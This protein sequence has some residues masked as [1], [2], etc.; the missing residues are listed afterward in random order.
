[1]SL[2]DKYAAMTIPRVVIFFILV[3]WGALTAP[4]QEPPRIVVEAPP[5]LAGTAAQLR[6]VDPARLASVMRLVGLREPGPP[7]RVILAPEES[8]AAGIVPSWVSGYAVG[9][10]GV[11]VL[12][13]GRVPSYPDSS[14][15][16]LLSHEMAHVL[17][18]RAAGGRPLPRWFHEGMA[19]IAGLSWGLDDRS[20]LTLALLVDRPVSLAG[21]DG[22]FAGGQSEVN[23]AYA[24]S[25]AFVRDLFD[26]YGQE[27][28]ARIL[29]E[30]SRGL[31]FPDA[32]RA[33]TGDSLATAE[34]SF[35]DRQTFWYRWVPALTS[36]VTLWMIVTLLA[37]WAMKRRRARDA[38]LRRRW[39]E[40][41]ERLRLAAE[42]PAETPPLAVV[43][44]DEAGEWVN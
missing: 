10:Q 15:P 6:S 14:L 4:A 25:G 20:R 28:A 3:L 30:V 9:E 36:S 12:L 29:R 5:R 13:P 41:D 39:D 11:I 44:K 37:L 8:L 21:L 40:E 27:V 22:R 16:D 7:V 38:A 34:S 31:S 43:P 33:A 18:A 19:M 17:V 32:F 23:R 35:W 26:R 2:F 24:I 42:A 1:M